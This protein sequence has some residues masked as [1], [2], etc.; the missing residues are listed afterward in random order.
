MLRLHL[1]AWQPITKEKNCLHV[2]EHSHTQD[3]RCKHIDVQAFSKPHPASMAFTTWPP[4]S[5]QSQPDT[6][7]NPIRQHNQEMRFAAGCNKQTSNCN[8]GACLC[9]HLS[10]AQVL[11]I[12]NMA[13]HSCKYCIA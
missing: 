2:L 12:V 9:R 5:T 6:S 7:V 3:C 1:T 13:P 10:L 4:P 8:A 11:S